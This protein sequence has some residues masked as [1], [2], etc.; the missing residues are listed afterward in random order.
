MSEM[1]RV[2][3]TGPG[4]FGLG[5]VPVPT[6]GPQDIVVRV[7][8][9][10]ICGSDTA[11]I[12]MGGLGGTPMPLGHEAAGEVSAVGSEVQG[13]ALGDRVVVNPMAAPS[14]VMGN[15]GALGA[16]APYLL[17]ENAVLGESVQ[18]IPASL[19][20]EVAALNEPMAVARH[21][22]NRANPS[23]G[24]TAVVFGAG[25]IGLGAAI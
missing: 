20:F 19:P 5:T 16:L 25:P 13:I 3:I 17:I 8:A 4:E 6:P 7:R 9:C 24:D 21:L 14:G 18:L 23:A 15:G 2:E 11:Y 1:Q 12:A 10:G 22:G